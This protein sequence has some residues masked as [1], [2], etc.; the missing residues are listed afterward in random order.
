MA[1]KCDCDVLETLLGDPRL[2]VLPLA[3]RCLW[4]EL[5]L[6]M[7]RL[8]SVGLRVGSAPMNR[9][10][11]ALLVASSETEVEAN[12]QPL[13]ACG[14]LVEEAD[15]ALASPLLQGAAKRSEINRIN[16]LKG[17]R[18]KGSG[19]DRRQGHM[20][21]PVR[22]GG[23]VETEKTETQAKL[24]AGAR[25]AAATASSQASLQQSEVMRIGDE[26]VEIAGLDPARWA[27]NYGIVGIWLA[28]GADGPMILDVAR[29]VAAR[30]V[31]VSTLRY[32]DGAVREAIARGAKP[33]YQPTLAYDRALEEWQ[34]R[35]Y[36]GPMP[37]LSDFKGVA[38]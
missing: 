26:L 1:R 28:A 32:F 2:R 10:Q 25:A 29:E 20:M 17:G 12:I 36:A 24:L 5:V 38:A 16:G 4:V 30:G 34:Y 9:A 11:L 35:N 19:A 8:G 13:L 18:P 33:A 6:A 27:G 37:K 22:G 3:T 14:L 15:G 23:G 7:R 21:M 31:Q